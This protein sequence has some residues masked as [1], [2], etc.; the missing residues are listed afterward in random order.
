MLSSCVIVNGTF[1]LLAGAVGPP[2][3]WTFIALLPKEHQ[4]GSANGVKKETCGRVIERDGG[5]GSFYKTRQK[6]EKHGRVSSPVSKSLHFMVKA[7]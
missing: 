2:G 4:G 1:L 7:S 6:R 5:R 3:S